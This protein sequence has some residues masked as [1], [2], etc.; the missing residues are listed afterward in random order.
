MTVPEVADYLQ[1]SCNAVYDLVR[2]WERSEGQCGLRSVRF[3]RLI[4]IRKADVDKY[5]ASPPSAPPTPRP[6]AAAP[7]EFPRRPRRPL[8][9]P[10]QE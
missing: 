8:R 5:L 9:S 4:R 1:I 7:R 3:G 10:E 2:T 6:D